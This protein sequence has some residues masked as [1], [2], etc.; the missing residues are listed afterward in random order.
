MNWV[1]IIVII[2][3][4]ISFLG[5]MKDGAVKNFFSLLILII[6]I[7]LTGLSYR[8]IAAILSFLPGTNWENFIGFFVTMVI[9]SIILH[10]ILFLPRR[11][12]QSIWKKG[13]LFRLLGGA[14][15][16]LSAI[17]G[18]VVFTLVLLSFPIFDWLERW[19][20]GSGVLT[21][22]V[23][24][25]GFVESMLPELFRQVAPFVPII[26]GIH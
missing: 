6:A 20:S 15:N 4:V 24:S 17:I 5:G 3:L 7:P 10:V 11:I 23:D 12:T 8:L 19:V 13:I 9:I 22:L 25:F 2:L 1:D 18:M 26:T 14:F 21:S 16:I